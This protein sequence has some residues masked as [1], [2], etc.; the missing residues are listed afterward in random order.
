MKKAFLTAVVCALLSTAAHAAERFVAITHDN[1]VTQWWAPMIKGAKDA[2]KEVGAE[3]Q[4]V[5]NPSG[6]MAQMAKLVEAAVATN[7]DGIFL[8]LPDPDTLAPAVKAAVAA[9]IPVVTFNSGADQAKSMGSLNHVGQP[10]RLA[11]KAAGERAKAEG[12]TKSICLNHETANK[13]MADRCEGFF[14][15][16]GQPLN[17]IDSSND[18]TQ[19]KARLSAALEADQSLDSVIALDPNVCE[20]AAAAIAEVGAK[21]HLSCFDLSPGILNLIK[22]GKVAFTIDQQPYLQGYMPVIILH[23]YKNYGVLPANDVLSGPGFV[24]K[25]NV[26]LVIKLAGVAR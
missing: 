20:A 1:G 13:S 3:L 26:D 22:D 7:P 15:G 10:E 9:G 21:V 11:G 2:A 19:V 18:N 12:A 25:T 8:S 23:L 6:D 4:Y 24:D 14:E 17:M 5:P 16:L